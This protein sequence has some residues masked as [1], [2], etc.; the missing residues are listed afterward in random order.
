MNIDVN[1]KNK[2]RY[3]TAKRKLKYLN[4][5]LIIVMRLMKL[6]LIQGIKLV[7]FVL[8]KQLIF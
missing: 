4:L 7:V 8:I 2:K 6:L 5:E 1:Y 3:N